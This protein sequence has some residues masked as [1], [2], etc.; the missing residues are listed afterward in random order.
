MKISEI[1]ID[2]SRTYST[3]ITMSRA[4]KAKQI[5]K[6]IVDEDVAAQYTRL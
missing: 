6:R 4:W 5:A 1:I 3:G 2:I